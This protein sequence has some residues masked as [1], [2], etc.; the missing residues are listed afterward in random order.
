MHSFSGFEQDIRTVPLLEELEMRRA[1]WPI[2]PDYVGRSRSPRH[3]E[4]QSEH[5]HCHRLLSKVNRPERLLP[6]VCKV[7]YDIHSLAFVYNYDEL[8]WLSGD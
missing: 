1:H 5:D 4:T 7:K 3:P 6:I 2:Q 8:K